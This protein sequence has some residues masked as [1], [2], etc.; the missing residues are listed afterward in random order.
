MSD[1]Y[2]RD[3]RNR[4]Q[5]QYA[6]EYRH[7]AYSSVA[8][9]FQQQRQQQQQYATQLDFR[10]DSVFPR[11][12]QPQFA[13]VQQYY[14]PPP[15]LNVAQTAAPPSSTSGTGPP[16]GERTGGGG[17]GDGPTGQQYHRSDTLDMYQDQSFYASTYAAPAQAPEPSFFSEYSPSAA[18]LQP[19][20]GYYPP[21]YP[22]E[23]Y[24]PPP[25]APAAYGNATPRQVGPPG[26]AK[27]SGGGGGGGRGAAVVPVTVVTG[28]DLAGKG[29][30]GVGAGAFR[31]KRRCCCCI[32]R[33]RRGK[34]GCG[35]G[36]LFVL[37]AMGL[38]AFFFIPRFPSVT[39]KS[40]RIS[41]GSM[42]GITLQ[43]PSATNNQ[44]FSASLPVT[45]KVVATSTNP[46][47]IHVDMLQVKAVVNTPTN[48][49]EPIGTGQ[50]GQLIFAPKATTQFG[51]N[52]T[53]QFTQVGGIASLIQD[54]A[55][56]QFL[57]SCNISS[58]FSTAP[59]VLGVPT[60]IDY[61]TAVSVIPLNKVGI[62]PRL[63]G[64]FTFPCPFSGTLLRSMQDLAG[65]LKN[66][67]LSIPKAITQAETIL[68]GTSVGQSLLNGSGGD[69]ANA[70]KSFGL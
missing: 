3:D 18:L 25:A 7:S 5:P 62:V 50:E 36:I 19:Q 38:I 41:S 48:N 34:F 70:L 40:F 28:K 15:T 31:P 60:Q 51:L 9:P 47:P 10:P 12:M 63:A 32:P 57:A 55:L 53:I 65:G 66:G 23:Q 54:P 42:S 11:A 8:P 13:Q 68:A 67:T 2:Y 16:R 14:V 6:Q 30:V 1:P 43:L 37:V 45:M 20:Q 64:T 58:P 4:K 22:Q 44:T 61:E 59:V 35:F 29:K 33:S 56:N 69:L 27:K 49:A 46:Y 21:Q 24:M 26:M 39:V 17:G 52:F